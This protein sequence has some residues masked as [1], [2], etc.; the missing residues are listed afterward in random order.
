[1]QVVV[2]VLQEEPVFVN[3]KGMAEQAVVLLAHQELAV[4]MIVDIDLPEPGAH[5]QQLE[6]DKQNQ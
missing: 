6:L 3:I 1:L 5:R 4:Q 2:A